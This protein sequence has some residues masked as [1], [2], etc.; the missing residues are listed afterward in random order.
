MHLQLLLATC[1]LLPAGQ[2]PTPIEEQIDG[3]CYAFVLKNLLA[4]K[5]DFP[6]DEKTIRAALNNYR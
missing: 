3:K 2:E 5:T 4:E 6:F 1:H